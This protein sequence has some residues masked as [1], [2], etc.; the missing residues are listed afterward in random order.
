MYGKG[1]ACQRLNKYLHNSLLPTSL[2]FGISL[3]SRTYI[4]D[5]YR[6]VFLCNARL[7]FFAVHLLE[8]I[9][10][11]EVGSWQEYLRI[12]LVSKDDLLIVDLFSAR[13]DL[14]VVLQ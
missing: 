13:G 2:V 14:K 6:L 9:C 1:A 5:W 3:L 7:D 12:E 11:L 10:D 8:N 4:N